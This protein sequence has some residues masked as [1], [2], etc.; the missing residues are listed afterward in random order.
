[1][2]L[3]A[4][5]MS[6]GKATDFVPLLEPGSRPV[7]MAW[8][9]LPRSLPALWL[10]AGYVYCMLT[11]AMLM[12]R[13]P[14]ALVGIDTV[15]PMGAPLLLS[16]SIRD[17]WGRRWNLVI[18]RLMKRTFFTPLVGC[19]RAAR[20]LGGALSFLMSGLFHEYMWLAVNWFQLC[21]EHYVPGQ[22]LLFFMLQFAL[23]AAE[24]NTRACHGQRKGKCS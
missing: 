5:I 19:S 7:E 18:H 16:T 6:V 13:V 20:H 24:A 21:P 3:G 23:C 17:F 12:H 2:L 15:D 22:V 9:G 1:M 14:C 10:Q 4:V 11:T 8:Y